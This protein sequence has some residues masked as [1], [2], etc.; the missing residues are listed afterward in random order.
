MS[1]LYRSVDRKIVIL[2]GTRPHDK[3]LDSILA[4]LTNVL[5]KHK[6]GGVQTFRLR[7]I[8]LNR[9]VNCFNCWI[10]TPGR[11]FHVDAGAEILQAILNSN[12]VILFTP[13]VFEAIHRNLRKS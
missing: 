12:T 1:K 13:V 9:C 3:D 2:D 10:K 11:C 5:H 4:L 8:K 6:G 7:D